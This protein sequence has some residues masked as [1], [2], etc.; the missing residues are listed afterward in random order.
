MKSKYTGLVLLATLATSTTMAVK[1]TPWGADAK[2]LDD[3]IDVQVAQL[4]KR[5]QERIEQQTELLN[6]VERLLKADSRIQ[7]NISEAPSTLAGAAPMPVQTVKTTPASPP[8]ATAPWWTQYQPKMV[9]VSPTTRY[10][11]INGQMFN[12]GQSPG[13]GVL[14]DV[15]DQDTVV[16]RRGAERHTYLLEK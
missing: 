3:R 7:G 8:P 9:Y 4:D 10:T 13:E 14:V 6:L 12:A 5:L 15:I 2:P 16:L 11:V 1:A